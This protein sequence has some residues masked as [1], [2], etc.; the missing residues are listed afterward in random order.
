[1]SSRTSSVI[2][3]EAPPDFHHDMRRLIAAMAMVLRETVAAFEDT[4]ARITEM[5]VLRHRGNHD[6]ELIVAL[7]EFDKLQQEFAALSELLLRL[8]VAPEDGRA[9]LPSAAEVLPA[10]AIAALRDRL[11]LRLNEHPDA[12]LE[13][14][15]KPGDMEF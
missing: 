9:T 4:V 8:S 15:P 10:I 3:V 6:R 5:T 13:L 7:Q 1:M 2:A 11:T 12:E 14:A